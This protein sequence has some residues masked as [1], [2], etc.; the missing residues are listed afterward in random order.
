MKDIK[1]LNK[2]K[3][4][5]GFWMGRLNVVKM[6]GLPNLIYKHKAISVKI[7]AKY[8]MDIDTHSKG[9]MEGQKTQNSQYNSE[10]KQSWKTGR[11]C[12]TLRLTIKLQ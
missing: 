11:H 2:W 6:S 1:Q 3:Y 5:P 7:P 8:F 9:Y 4:I 10:V 12:L